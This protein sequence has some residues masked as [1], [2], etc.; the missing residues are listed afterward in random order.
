MDDGETKTTQRLCYF[1]Q[2]PGPQFSEPV[3]AKETEQQV[4]QVWICDSCKGNYQPSRNRRQICL[5][6]KFLHQIPTL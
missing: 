6:Q 5:H 2:S 1:C 4:S 3:K